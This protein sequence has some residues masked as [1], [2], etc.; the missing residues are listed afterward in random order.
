[1]YVAKKSAQNIDIASPIF[2]ENVKL[3]FQIAK[4]VIKPW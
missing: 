2:Q 3:A 4:E 1:M